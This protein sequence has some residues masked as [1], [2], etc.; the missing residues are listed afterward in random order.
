M[1]TIDAE[2]AADQWPVGF[3]KAQHAGHRRHRFSERRTHSFDLDLHSLD[4]LGAVSSTDT[5]SLDTRP[6]DAAFHPLRGTLAHI[7]LRVDH[8]DAGRA[9]HD[10]VDIRASASDAAV[11][12]GL[13][14]VGQVL[15]TARQELFSD[16]AAFPSLRALRVIGE[17]EDQPAELRMVG[18]DLLFPVVSAALVFASRRCPRLASVHSRDLDRAVDTADGLRAA[19]LDR[20]VAGGDLPVQGRHVPAYHSRMRLS[21]GPSSSV[22]TRTYQ[23]GSPDVRSRQSRP[24]ASKYTFVIGS[25]IA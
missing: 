2:G 14:G 11:M 4:H 22:T 23:P 20:F 19:L 16:G 24:R 8:P 10:V 15:Q 7:P 17:R 21:S 13:E 12:Q 5:Q 6:D 25:S 1:H 9:D 18:T 3:E